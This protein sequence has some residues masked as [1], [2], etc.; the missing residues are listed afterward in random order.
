MSEK[1]FIKF[2]SI[3]QFRNV[4]SSVTSNCKYNEVPLPTIEFEGTVKLHGTNAGVV[5]SPNGDVYAQ[6]RNNILSLEKDNAGFAFFVESNKG[7]FTDLLNSVVENTGEEHITIFGEWCG[8]GIQKGVGISELDKMFVVFGCKVGEEWVGYHYLESP[9]N[10]IYN[11]KNF[12]TYKMTIDFSNPQISTNKLVEITEA[13]EAECPVAKSFGVSGIGEGV[14]WVANWNNQHLMF[15]VKG[16]KHSSSKVKK[17]ATVDTEKL[18][19]IQ[20]FVEYSVTENRL[21]QAVE[22]VF[23]INNIEPDIKQ[24]GDFLGW[25]VRDILK[26][27][28]DTMVASGLE[29][30]QVNGAISKHARQWWMTFLNNKTLL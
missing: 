17:L 20:K 15:K 27:E 25:V 1:Q 6:S 23:T 2:P 18:E 4:V 10:R 19:N 30:K 29:P 24:T 9:E 21:N 11:I 28:L 8:A 13:V 12:P 16:E 26:E 14:V 3:E 7:V 5:M 22:Q